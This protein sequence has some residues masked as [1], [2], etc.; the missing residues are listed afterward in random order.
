MSKDT[1]HISV[2]AGQ[3]EFIKINAVRWDWRDLYHWL[4]TLSWPLFMGVLVALYLTINAGF[5][6]LYLCGDHCIAEVPAV[7]LFRRFLL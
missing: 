4:L 1:G 3:I 7:L 2:R 5:A 6:L